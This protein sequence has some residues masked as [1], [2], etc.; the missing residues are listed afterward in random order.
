MK[1]MQHLVGQVMPDVELVGS[2][3]GLTNPK[4]V[5]G[6][7]VYFCYPYTGRPGVPNPRG[8]DDIV[9]AHGSTPQALA[10]VEL[11]KTFTAIGARVFGVSLLLPEWI[12]DFANRNDVPFDLLSDD[13]GNFSSGL[14]LPRFMIDGV[15][16]LRRITL[17]AH[18]GII[19]HVKFPVENP[20]QDAAQILAELQ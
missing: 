12:C 5:A 13:A 9:G 8:W 6:R 4:H 19:T 14:E 3:G 17:V 2:S 16:F 7:A 18:A 11:H 20:E 1:A 10:Y 15:D